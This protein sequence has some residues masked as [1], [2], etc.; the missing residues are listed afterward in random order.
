MRRIA[1][2]L[3]VLALL[4]G[5]TAAFALTE[6][7]K[8]EGR[9]ISKVRVTEA[10]APEAPCRPRRAAFVFTMR[11]VGP[12]DADVVDGDGW[13]V[14]TLASDLA[15]DERR[16]RLTWD[17]TRDDGGRAAEGEYR[18]RLYLHREDRTVTMPKAVRL[19]SARE[20]AMR[21]HGARA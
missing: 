9:A 13:A 5:T 7:L 19:E 1:V 16:I 8:L 18:L 6:A 3:L 10:F 12:I 15:P 2:T 11:R 4:G 20:A 17:G 14:R 21:C